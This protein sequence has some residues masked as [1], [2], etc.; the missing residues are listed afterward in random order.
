MMSHRLSGL[1]PEKAKEIE[2]FYFDKSSAFRNS[3]GI[4]FKIISPHV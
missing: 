1:L 3:E 4:I 2:G